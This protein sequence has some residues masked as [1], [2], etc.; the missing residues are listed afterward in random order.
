MTGPGDED[1]VAMREEPIDAVVLGKSL[2]PSMPY[3]KLIA[4]KYSPASSS[5]ES[6]KR[7]AFP[8]SGAVLVLSLLRRMM[9][10]PELWSLFIAVD[11]RRRRP[12]CFVA[13][14]ESLRMIPGDLLIAIAS[15]MADWLDFR[16]GT[17]DSGSCSK[18]ERLASDSRPR[19]PS[20]EPWVEELLVV[21]SVASGDMIGE[22][23]PELEVVTE[24]LLMAEAG[25]E[26]AADVVEDVKLVWT[27]VGFGCLVE[28]GSEVGGNLIVVADCCEI[29]VA[30]KGGLEVLGIAVL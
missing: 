6:E 24:E 7:A 22:V 20:G 21:T 19:R 16:E 14:F 8:P 3:G 27:R 2:Y 11:D 30:N 29:A 13:L 10:G 26:V 9:T 18:C 28:E 23:G 25:T 1:A 17:I 12:R 15:L 5:S 4:S